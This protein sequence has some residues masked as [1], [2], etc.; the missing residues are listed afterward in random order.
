MNGELW[1]IVIVDDSPEDRAEA[2]RLLLK[3]SDR[4]YT[5]TEADTGAAGLRALAESATVMATA[6]AHR[7]IVLDYNLPDMAAPEF[8]AA[9]SG[10]DGAPAWPVVVFTGGDSTETGRSALRAGAHDYVG[11]NALTPQTLARAVESASE[12]WAMASELRQQTTAANASE[13]YFE[14][15]AEA[16]SDVAYRM[17]ADWSLML[18]LNG[19]ALVASTDKPLAGWAWL[20]QNIPADEHARVRQA[21]GDAIARKALFSLEH[22]VRRPDGSIGWTLS[23]AVPILDAHGNLREWFGAASD[24]TERRQAEERLRLAVAGSD[25]GTWHWDVRTGALDWSERCL[26]IFGLP[27]RTAMSYEKFIDTLHPDDRARAD[28]TVQRALH[29][30]SDYRIELRSV[31][32][33][34]SMH[35]ALSIG[36]AYGDADGEPIRMEG[37]ALDITERKRAEAALRETERN[38]QALAEASAEV[39]YRMSADWSTM[40]A[41]DG[42]GL[43][44]SSGPVANWAWVEEYLPRDE[45][46]RVRQAI[47]DAIAKKNIFDLEHRVLRADGS[48]GWVRSRAVP[49]LDENGKLVTWFGAGSDITARKDAEAALARSEAFARSVVGANADCMKGLSLDGRLMW[50]NDNGKRLMEVGDFAAL[51]GTDWSN[52]WKAGG[53]QARAEVALAT[54]RAGGTGR[55]TGFC[56]TFAGNPRWWDVAVTAI[57]GD[58]GR[59]EQLLAVSRD[60]TEQRAAD[61][62]TRALAQRLQL[63]LDCSAVVLFQ[64]DLELRYTWIYNPVLGFEASQVVGKFDAELMEVSADAEAVTAQKRHVM[65]SG[66]GQQTEAVIHHQ[67]V[68]HWYRLLIEP[69][70]DAVGGMAGVTCAAIDITEIKQA[71]QALVERDVQKNVFLATLAHEL[72]SPLAPLRTGLQL[73]KLTQHPGNAQRTHLMMERQLGQMVR[74]V[75]DLLDISRITHSKVVLRL[76]CIELQA[77]M[78]SAIEAALPLLDA[79]RQVLRVEMPAEPIW[80]QADP[81]RVIQVVNNL[82]ANAAKYSPQ[83]SRIALGV[84]R[85]GTEAVVTVADPGQ[86]I[87]QDMLAHIF[88]MFTQVDHT[89][90]RAQGGLGIGLALVKQLVEM[91]GGAVSVRSAGLGLGCTFTVRLPM[92]D[93]VPGLDNVAQASFGAASATTQTIATPTPTPTPTSTRLRVLV[94][95]DNADAAESLAELMALDGHETRV[96]DSGLAALAMVREFKPVLVFLDIGMPGMSGHEAARRLRADDPLGTL[97]LVALTGWGADADRIETRA[98][99]FDLHFTKPLD[100]DELDSVLQ[101]VAQRQAKSDAA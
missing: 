59:A 47:S 65:L 1:H 54:A 94:V 95:D 36:R 49:I 58:D 79:S 44:A 69:L 61:E 73:L 16:T 26:A 92:L 24:I 66:V 52:L 96:A 53:L 13:Q 90:E 12:R 71:E 18:P 76:A 11:K 74:L 84:Q 22:R 32:P 46:A 37:I 83:G 68:A 85:V 93:G 35:W 2:R 34:G 64:Q 45:Q 86:G 89:L 82:L 27:A 56:P 31:W 10:S 41:L 43:F 50:M 19:R 81:T 97:T 87:P 88:D 21:I 3:H 30:G 25:L 40:L 99:G 23:R 29:S 57:P 20:A 48:T 8:L 7:C 80:L 101:Q 55:F 62:A 6:A 28:D 77:T 39:P 91:H 78:H 67:G 5:F 100:M 9:I 75:D 42:R 60:V 14:A 17:S 33:D 98:A 38:Y 51:R 63:A 15:L 72:R 4:R 70:R